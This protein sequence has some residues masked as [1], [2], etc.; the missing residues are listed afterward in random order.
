MPEETVVLGEAEKHPRQRTN[1]I[2]ISRER[3]VLHDHSPEQEV[4]GG[5]EVPMDLFRRLWSLA[6]WKKPGVVEP[7][8]GGGNVQK[9]EVAIGV[10][11]LEAQGRLEVVSTNALWRVV[12][13]LQRWDDGERRARMASHNAL[14]SSLL[15]AHD[16]PS[17]EY[18]ESA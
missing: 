1:H 8:E 3:V 17:E 6:Y 10:V 5:I 7:G 4:P 11:T 9:A 16:E 14:S 18:E 12:A 2:H 15:R 13:V